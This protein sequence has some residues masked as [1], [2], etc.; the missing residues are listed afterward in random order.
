MTG[1]VAPRRAL[2]SVSDK[3][4]LIDFARALV[5]AGVELVSTGGS[6]RAIRDAGI[7]VREVSE[8]TGF[9]EIMDG[10]VKSLHPAIHG[11]ILA[12]RDR[13]DDMATLDEHGIGPIDLV[14]VNL[15]PFEETV[16]KPGVDVGV[17]L[18]NIDIGGPSM[19]RSAAKNWPHVV[20]VPDA[21]EYGTVLD[22]LRAGGVTLA[23]RRRLAAATFAR[24]A[25]YNDAIARYLASDAGGVDAGAA[26]GDDDP[27]AW[28]ERMA[29]ALVR[30]A[31]LRYGENPH[32]RGAFYRPDGARTGVAGLT[33][34]QGKAISYNNLL[35]LDAGWR[36]AQAL[37]A[38]SAVVIK[39]RNP[40][41]AAEASDLATAFADAWRG[42]GLSAFGGV[43]LLRGR[44]DAALAATLKEN[45]VEL[46]AAE[47]FD[48]DARTV[49]AKK[50]NLILLEGSSLSATG[51]PLVPGTTEI[52]SVAGA[53][54]AQ[55]SD[56]P[57]A[58]GDWSLDV[59]TDRAPDD[60]EMAS[61][62]F[63]WQ[64]CRYVQ[65]NAIVFVQGTRTV[66][67]GCGQTSRV[68][69]V[70]LAAMKAEREGHDLTGSVLASDAFFPFG[71]SVEL[72]ASLGCRAVIQPGGSKRDQ[73]SID[74]ANA[75]E[76]AM[77]VTGRRSF[78]H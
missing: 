76:M 62:R 65:S 1:R 20:V 72:A 17:A 21:R 49:L 39:H 42:D 74:A 59:V 19:L 54:L 2:L 67:V 33:Q 18:E 29:P 36:L 28:P 51:A 45:F 8:L 46:I 56:R 61:L 27:A 38:P 26:S 9:P 5:E 31:T 78:R 63:A 6:A 14:C 66:G 44:V 64:V 50:K 73:E 58:E 52:R 48:D 12:R 77:L 30:E 40:A 35:D 37:R 7:A 24:C 68:D 71:D 10:R 16:T 55:E 47:A 3:T 53:V 57:E 4:G 11:G 41:G 69:A 15:Y 23:T 22:E 60:A 70:R 13:D 75:A 32:Q 25:A 34:L 43:I